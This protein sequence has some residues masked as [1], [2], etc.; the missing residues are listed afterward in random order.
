MTLSGSRVLAVGYKYIQNTPISSAKQL[1]RSDLESKLEFGG[2][3][4]VSCPLK[5]DSKS[6]MKDI[7]E[8]SHHVAMITGDNELTACHVAKELKI[9]DPAKKDNGKIMVLR[10]VENKRN[11]TP[12]YEKSGSLES[13]LEGDKWAWTS[14]DGKHMLPLEKEERNAIKSG[15]RNWWEKYSFCLT[16]TGLQ[17]LQDLSAG[18]RFFFFFC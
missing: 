1:T 12:E 18:L 5:S 16:G 9:V 4:V 10:A 14:I 2:F 15:G 11:G 3:L 7:L 6:V 17:F 13:K 8:S